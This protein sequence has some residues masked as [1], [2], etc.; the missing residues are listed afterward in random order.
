VSVKPEYFSPVDLI[1]ILLA[2]VSNGD[3]QTS[4]QAQVLLVL[5]FFWLVISEEG[6]RP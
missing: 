1:Q 6:R 5:F 2:V 3:Q 4:V